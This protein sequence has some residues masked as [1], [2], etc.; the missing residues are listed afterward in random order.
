MVPT[1]GLMRSS[2]V[3]TMAFQSTT[4]FLPGSRWFLG[5]LEFLTA[6]FGNLSLQERELSE[7]IRS[8]TGRLPLA[9]VQVSLIIEEWLGLSSLGETDALLMEDRADHTLVAQVAT[10]DLIYTSS[11]R[12]DSEYKREFYMVEQVVSCPRNPLKSSK[13]KPRKR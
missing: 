13:G 6:K 10:T 12:S 2:F 1:V 4:K 11:S 3:R 5:S 7:V 9:S 8:G